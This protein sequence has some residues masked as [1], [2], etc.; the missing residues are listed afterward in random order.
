MTIREV[1]I[2]YLEKNNRKTIKEIAEGINIDEASVRTTIFREGYGLLAKGIVAKVSHEKRKGYFSL[3]KNH[4]DELK[5]LKFYDNLFKNNVDYLMKN[6]NIVRA[7]MDNSELTDK[8]DKV[9][10]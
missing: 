8:I 3:A 4:V 6:D 10:N 7:I 2:K 9:V 1:I 5:A